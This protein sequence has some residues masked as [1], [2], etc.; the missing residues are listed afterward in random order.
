V[1]AG[2][3]DLQYEFVALESALKKSEIHLFWAY[4]APDQLRIHRWSGGWILIKQQTTNG[5]SKGATGQ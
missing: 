3:I 4:K 2:D 5:P 1:L